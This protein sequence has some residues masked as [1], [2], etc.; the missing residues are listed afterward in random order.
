MSA[1]P[2]GS[3]LCAALAAI[4]LAASPAAAA[5]LADETALAERFA[6][7]VR[8]VEQAEE[9]G[10]G[11]PYRADRRRAALRRAD[12]RAARAVEPVDLVK[13]GPGGERPRRTST[14]TTSTSPGNALDPGCDYERWERRLTEG[15]ARPSTRT[16]RPTRAIPG[17]LAL[18]YWLFYTFNDWNNLHEGDWEMIQLVFDAADAR[19]GARRGPGRRSATASTRAPSGADWGDDKLELVDGPHPVVY[20]AAGSHANFFD[21]ALYVGSSGEQGVGCDDTRGPHLELRAEVVHDPERCRGRARGVPVDHV[22]GALGRAPGRVLQRP[23]GAQPEAAMDRADRLVGALARPQLRGAR[24]AALFGTGATD[25][26]CDA[27][28]TGSRGLIRLLRA[29]GADAA[30]ARGV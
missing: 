25:F 17:K 30:R 26:F 12:R 24:R 15:H 16:S 9:C 8:L 20:P 3:A 1:R 28:A 13:I 19:G 18:Q 27:V 10:P 4:T 11:E 29:A 5:G 2:R 21:S 23:D 7:V 22:R 14:S 6:P